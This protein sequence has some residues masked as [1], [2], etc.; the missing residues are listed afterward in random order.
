MYKT[1]CLTKIVCCAPQVTFLYRLTEGACPKSYGP[2][3]ARLAGLPPALV[4]RAS[5]LSAQL[6]SSAGNRGMSLT[7]ALKRRSCS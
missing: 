7:A 6:E 4:K 2:N 5:E 3:V 1:S